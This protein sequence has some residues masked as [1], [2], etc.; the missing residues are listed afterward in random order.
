MNFPAGKKNRRRV[1]E[2]L[3]LLLQKNSEPLILSWEIKCHVIKVSSFQ[4]AG[5]FRIMN[6]IR[7]LQDD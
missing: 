7:K 4:I 2:I 1:K 5:P 6:D 3:F